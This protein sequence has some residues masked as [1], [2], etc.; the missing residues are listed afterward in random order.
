[1]PG[2]LPANFSKLFFEAQ[3][4]KINPIWYGLHSNVS[5]VVA[6][7]YLGREQNFLVRLLNSSISVRVTQHRL[8]IKITVMIVLFLSPGKLH[9]LVGLYDGIHTGCL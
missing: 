5:R 3:A 1:M 9:L 8:I 6:D 2:V 7:V 4:E